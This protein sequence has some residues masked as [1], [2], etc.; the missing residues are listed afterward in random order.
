[1]TGL[2]GACDQCLARGRRRQDARA[3]A[4]SAPV[5]PAPRG[6]PASVEGPLRGV[7]GAAVIVS[8]T[9]RSK[10]SL[11]ASRRGHPSR[12]FGP[13]RS[14]PWSCHHLGRIVFFGGKPGREMRG[15]TIAH[16]SSHHEPH[17]LGHRRH[18]PRPFS[19]QQ[20]PAR[21]PPPPRRRRASALQQSAPHLSH[22]AS[23]V[24]PWCWRRASSSHAALKCSHATRASMFGR[25]RRVALLCFSIGPRRPEL[26][27]TCL[28]RRSD[29]ASQKPFASRSA[30]RGCLEGA[31][32]HDQ[33]GPRLRRPRRWLVSDRGRRAPHDLAGHLSQPPL[34]AMMPS[35][36]QDGPSALARRRGT[37][38]RGESL[39]KVAQSKLV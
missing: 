22:A 10:P 25:R 33:P 18:P 28:V 27:R 15:P 19:Q 29:I 20:R 30:G 31:E 9:E 3:H 11:S 4:L 6:L 24:A 1:V 16:C 26:V 8:L 5:G 39:R 13:R 38:P 12:S 36:R 23:R 17:N 2:V 37:P 21:P 14:T 32:G 35:R 7:L 34:P